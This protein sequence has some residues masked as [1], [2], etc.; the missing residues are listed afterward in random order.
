MSFENPAQIVRSWALQGAFS[1]G[2][3]VQDKLVP[4]KFARIRTPF[5]HTWRTEAVNSQLDWGVQAAYIPES[6]R[7]ISSMFLEIPLPALGGGG[8]K[9]IPGLYAIKTIR[10][11]SAG[12]SPTTARWASTFGTTSSPVRQRK[13]TAS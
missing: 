5:V 8:Y 1:S 12:R 9:T 7:V 6:L 13:P 3:V 4:R 2:A 11:L 10:F